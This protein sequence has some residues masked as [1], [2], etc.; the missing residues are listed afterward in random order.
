MADPMLFNNCINNLDEHSKCNGKLDYPC[1]SMQPA[2]G[3]QAALCEERC[4]SGIG[5]MNEKDEE[6][7]REIRELSLA[8]KPEAAHSWKEFVS[9]DGDTFLHLAIIHGAGD[10]VFQILNNTRVGDQYLHH[11]NNL[12]Q[13][14]MHLA[15]ITQQPKVL[16]AL[17]WAGGD[18]GLRDINGN[19][20]LHIACEM[21]LFLC[22]EAISDF[23]T[24]HDIR[25]LLDSKNYN[26]L[27][28]L[29]LA[30][31]SRL[32]QMVKYLTQLGADINAQEPSSGRTALHLAV[33]EQD[34]EMVSLLVRCGAD[35]NVLMYNGCTPYH[36][37]LGRDNSRIQ[38]E[39]IS[40]TDPSLCIMWEEEQMWE[41]ES[42]DWEVP[43]SYDDCAIGGLPLRC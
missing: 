37:T 36:L 7:L 20:P 33:E 3:K 4:D 38:T 42:S 41:S 13:T 30:V 10:I 5:S 32:H 11:Q 31:K 12:K 14:P 35:P 22:V 39:L 40:V 34:P 24:R 26:G 8:D 19:S 1:G 23:S 18:L 21:N 27:T 2:A 25:N 6:V 28:C 16:K 17:L 9:E 29:Q 43:F 15:V